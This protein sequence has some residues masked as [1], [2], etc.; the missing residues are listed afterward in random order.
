MSGA[1]HGPE[2]HVAAV[3]VAREFEDASEATAATPVTARRAAPADHTHHPS[4]RV[5]RQRRVVSDSRSRDLRS[6]LRRENR[7]EQRAEACHRSDVIH[8]QVCHA[9][10]L[11]LIVR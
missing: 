2:S 10:E 9:F 6:E 7:C 8:H 3:Q 5:H 1:I 11:L 4:R